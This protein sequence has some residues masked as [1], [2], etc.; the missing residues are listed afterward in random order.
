MAHVEPAEPDS[1]AAPIPVELVYA[2]APHKLLRVPL[3]LPAGSTVGQAW[4]AIGERPPV[5][6]LYFALERR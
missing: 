2:A 6:G 5:L 4:L 3:L 1:A